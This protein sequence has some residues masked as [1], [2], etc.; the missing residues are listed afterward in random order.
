M[1]QMAEWFALLFK[2]RYNEQSQDT[3]NAWGLIK[4][5]VT[6]LAVGFAACVGYWGYGF[7]I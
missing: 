1:I 3:V 5:I 6:A 2:I 7:P 4:L